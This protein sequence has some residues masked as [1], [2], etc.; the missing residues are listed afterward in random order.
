VTAPDPFQVLGVTASATDAELRSA[1]RRL[2]QRHHPDHNGGS[3]ESARRF[4]EVQEAYA[5]IKLRRTRHD[6]AQ[7]PGA[8][9]GSPSDIEARLA[10]ME[11]ELAQA[12]D[13]RERAAH[14]ER[15]AQQRAEASRREARRAA[16]DSERAS[17]DE[18]GYVASDD[19]FTKI[20][21]DLLDELGSRFAGE[22]RER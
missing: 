10:A 12:R 18:L 7:A 11:Q 6:A 16:S 2:V 21:D 5:A 22:D 9:A 4:T 15:E 3:P 17:D 19:S 20:F 8:A 13:R 1:Y 14:V